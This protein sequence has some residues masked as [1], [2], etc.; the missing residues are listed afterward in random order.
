MAP[1]PKKAKA[2]VMTRSSIAA[3]NQQF[4]QNQGMQ[5]LIDILSGSP[6]LI[7]ATLAATRAGLFEKEQQGQD[8]QQDEK[9][10]SH[11]V[12]KYDAMPKYF[13]A[14]LVA[15]MGLAQASPARA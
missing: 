4:I 13:V 11:S 1:K 14:D 7:S 10:F 8:Q 2:L 12:S 9:P 15:D 6:E 3:A 5:D